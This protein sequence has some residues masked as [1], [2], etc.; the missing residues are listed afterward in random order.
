MTPRDHLTRWRLVLGADAEQGLGQGLDGNAARQ[1]A[2]LEYLYGREYGQGRN[3]RGRGAPG[4]PGGSEDSV[5]SVP[6]WINDVHELFPQRTIERL[7]K[8]ALERYSIS[9]LVTNA[10]L[11]AV[12]AAGYS[13][14]DIVEIITHVGMNFLTNV[15]GKASRVDI[16]FPRVEL[17]LAA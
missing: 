13:D 17:A 6:D 14:A 2:A 4:S 16:D 11:L 10:D 3:V 12:R 7:E 9:E 1:D 5:L 15:L 8:D